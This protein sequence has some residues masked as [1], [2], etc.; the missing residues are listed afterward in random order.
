MYTR[1]QGGTTRYS[2]HDMPFTRT[3]QTDILLAQLAYFTVMDHLAVGPLNELV[4]EL[5][6]SHPSPNSLS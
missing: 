2:L 3:L 4:L 5:F 6:L 1:I